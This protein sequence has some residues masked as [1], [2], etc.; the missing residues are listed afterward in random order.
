MPLTD[1]YETA[2]SPDPLLGIKAPKGRFYE[3]SVITQSQVRAYY[4][5]VCK[6][7]SLLLERIRGRWLVTRE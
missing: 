2:E 6:G 7:T 5:D 3:L 1:L 4:G